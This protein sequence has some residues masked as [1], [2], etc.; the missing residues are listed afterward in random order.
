MPQAAQAPDRRP[1]RDAVSW[2]SADELDVLGNLGEPKTADWTVLTLERD[3]PAAATPPA[4]APSAANAHVA[5]APAT[6]AEPAAGAAGAAGAR[7][8]SLLGTLPPE[9]SAQPAE[10]TADAATSATTGRRT[11]VIRGQA[12]PRPIVAGNRRRPASRRRDRVGHRPDR[13]AMWAVMLGLL[14]ILVA[15]TTASAA[16]PV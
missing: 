15:A 3:E 1:R 8:A 16:P 12:T 7:A 13:V 11:I 4:A 14:L 10:P 5:G 9:P 2:A 6:A